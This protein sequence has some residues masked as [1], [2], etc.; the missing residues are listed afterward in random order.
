MAAFAHDNE[1]LSIR[2]RRSFPHVRVIGFTGYAGAGKTT[3]AKVLIEGLAEEVDG[4][5]CSFAAPLRRICKEVFPYVDAKYFDCAGLKEEPIP[6]LNGLT[7]RRILQHIG[8][9][10][11]RALLSD[12][13]IRLAEHQIWEEARAGEQVIVFDDVRFLNEATLIRAYG[14]L[15]RVVRPGKGAGEHASER[16]ID[17]LVCDNSIMNDSTLETLSLRVAHCYDTLE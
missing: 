9:E 3:A 1:P 16:H 4:V 14:Q 13:W 5:R 6:G 7:G 10:G 17:A 12:T 8:T 11:F 15:Y 2:F